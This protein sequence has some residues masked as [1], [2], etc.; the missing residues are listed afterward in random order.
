MGIFTFDGLTPGYPDVLCYWEDVL[1]GFKCVSGMQRS[2]A[3]VLTLSW[4]LLP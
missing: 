1:Q 3:A 2:S 4:F